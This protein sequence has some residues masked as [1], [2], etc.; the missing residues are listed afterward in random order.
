MG[1]LKTGLKSSSSH[2]C[3]GTIICAQS[4]AA[5]AMKVRR[6]RPGLPILLTTAAAALGNPNCDALVALI[7]D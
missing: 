1:E 6:L 7:P 2:L 5:D 4:T 3:I